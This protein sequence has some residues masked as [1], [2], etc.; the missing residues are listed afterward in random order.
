MCTV[1]SRAPAPRLSQWLL[2]RL[3]ER[4]FAAELRQRENAI[5]LSAHLGNGRTDR[6]G[7]R[8]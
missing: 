8:K 7:H 6:I 5:N 4:H 2:L 3:L 1:S